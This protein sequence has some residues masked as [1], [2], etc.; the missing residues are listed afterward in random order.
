MK[1]SNELDTLIND[2]AIR[3]FWLKVWTA[4]AVGITVGLLGWIAYLSVPEGSLW[5]F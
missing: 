3:I 4:A 1:E 2:W 5:T